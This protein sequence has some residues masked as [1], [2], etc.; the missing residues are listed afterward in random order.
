VSGI[1]IGLL[2]TGVIVFLIVIV[3]RG[4]SCRYSSSSRS[5]K[6]RARGFNR[7]FYDLD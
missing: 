6:A 2:I 5:H 1:A 4:R 7:S 3:P